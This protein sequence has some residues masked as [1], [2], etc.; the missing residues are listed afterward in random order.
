MRILFPEKAAEATTE[1]HKEIQQKCQLLIIGHVVMA[2]YSFF[3]VNPSTAIGQALY[4][5]ILV[6]L[7][8]TFN[9]CM[10]YVYVALLVFNI[11][12][13]VLSVLTLQQGFF[14]YALVIVYY[15]FALKVA[16]SLT[17]IG[18]CLGGGNNN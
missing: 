15:L 13:G 8:M 1:E 9:S 2:V 10:K 17:M 3:F 7:Y 14:F 12:N 5:A 6:S 18:A 4:I 16:I 11:F